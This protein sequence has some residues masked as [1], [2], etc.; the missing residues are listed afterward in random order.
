MP[1]VTMLDKHGN[2]DT[3]ATKR[4]NRIHELS[5][6]FERK[7]RPSWD[8]GDVVPEHGSREA[9]EADEW[10]D[11]RWAYIDAHLVDDGHLGG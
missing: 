8:D 6:E 3:A 1:E 4:Q 11:A 7:N 10:H 2:V 5:A 9:R